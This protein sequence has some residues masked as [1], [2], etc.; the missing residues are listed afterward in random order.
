MAIMSGEQDL[1]KVAKLTGT[2]DFIPWRRRMRA[3]IQRTDVELLGLS[4]LPENATAAATNRWRT[5]MVKAKAAIVLTL[6]DGPM[7]QA[8]TVVEDM[9]K[10]AKDLWE[11]LEALYTASM[12]KQSSNSSKNSKAWNSRKK[13]T[14]RNILTSSTTFVENFRPLVELLLNKRWFRRWLVL[15]RSTSMPSQ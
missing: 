2:K 10:T 13:K 7:A 3:Y 5:A 8:G 12:S 9:E 15:F 6:G 4:E 1:F 11:Y 14:G